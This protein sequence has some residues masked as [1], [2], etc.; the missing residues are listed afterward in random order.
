[1]SRLFSLKGK[2]I[3]EKTR[4]H[5]VVSQF[6][7][8]CSING[9]DNLFHT[10][11]IQSTSIQHALYFLKNNNNKYDHS[12]VIIDDSSYPITGIPSNKDMDKIVDHYYEIFLLLRQLTTGTLTIV[13]SNSIIFSYIKVLLDDIFQWGDIFTDEN[14]LRMYLFQDK[15]IKSALILNA[16]SS[17]QPTI[18]EQTFIITESNISIKEELKKQAESDTNI[19]YKSFLI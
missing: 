17:Y 5:K 14:N 4:D 8:D 2:E 7:L 15:E 12:T 11:S 13:S 6:S 16:K 1:M 3:L 9:E 19:S 18:H 10:S